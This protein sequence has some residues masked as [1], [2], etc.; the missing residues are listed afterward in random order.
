MNTISI[1]KESTTVKYGLKY[2]KRSAHYVIPGNPMALARPR[3][4]I[5][6]RVY[7]AQKPQKLIHGITL[8]SQHNDEPFFTG[9][10]HLIMRFFFP[11]A[12]KRPHLENCWHTQRP[13]LSNCIKYYEDIATGICYK[14]DALITKIDATKFFSAIPRTELTILEL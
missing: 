14:D 9:P 11:M 5:K 1:I 8:Q 13:D 12:Q 3:F 7:D 10:L 4:G 2:H 6:G